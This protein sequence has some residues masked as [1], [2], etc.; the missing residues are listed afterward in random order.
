MR[1]QKFEIIVRTHCFSKKSFPYSSNSVGFCVKPIISIAVPPILTVSVSLLNILIPSALISLY[2]LEFFEKH[3]VNFVITKTIIHRC[4]FI[5]LF[6]Q[7]YYTAVIVRLT[8]QIHIT[9]YCDNIRTEVLT[10]AT[11]FR[12][13]CQPLNANRQVPQFGYYLQLYLILPDKI[14]FQVDYSDEQSS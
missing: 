13:P 10:S 1:Q 9:D 4:N 8:F 7:R 12:C 5:K 11:S 3:C 2:I 14:S 6:T